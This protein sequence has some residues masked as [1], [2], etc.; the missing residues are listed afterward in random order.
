MQQQQTSLPSF[1]IVG[2]GP[3]YLTVTGKN[4]SPSLDLEFL[5][6]REFSRA[7]EHGS[8]P[9]SASLLGYDGYKLDHY[10][11]GRRTDD[12]MV[13]VSGPETL[14]LAKELIQAASNISRL[15]LQVTIWTNGEQP[16]LGKH[17]YNH[18]TMYRR[19]YGRPGN[20]T[21]VQ[22]HPQGETLNVNK[23]T[24]DS[25]GRLYDK[26][27]EAKAGPARTIWR[28]EVEY[29][30]R[31]ALTRAIDYAASSDGAAFTKLAVHAWYTA[32]GLEPAF[33]TTEREP[34]VQASIMRPR[35]DVLSWF[36]ES[37]SITVARAVKT[38]GP[39]RVIKALGLTALVQP[40]K[41]DHNIE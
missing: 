31:A 4:G 13:R 21:L 24:S 23:R 37:V 17:G 22:N 16:H 18:L 19:A 40:R 33:K 25:F 29:K 10:F 38:Y 12:V 26:A 35:R 39:E 7:K 9:R 5:S 2:A 34:S 41:E 27:T 14:Y 30:R 8:K 11:F 3:D 1:P 36:E 15:D 20:I 6:D 28:Y 32:K